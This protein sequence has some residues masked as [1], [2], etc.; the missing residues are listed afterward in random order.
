M[1][2]NFL[3]NGNPHTLYTRTHHI[4]NNMQPTSKQQ[5][6]LTIVK[7]SAGSGKTFA[8]A[9]T[10]INILIQNPYAYRNILAVTFTNKATEEMKMR[11]L[12]QLYGIAN[13]L[14][15]S[16]DYLKEIIAHTQLPPQV[17]RQRA[18][19][20]LQLL[21]HNYTYFRVETIDAFFQSV[22]RNLARELDLT[23]NLRVE[24][25]DKQVQ[26]KAVDQLINQL[27]P[28]NQLLTWI[29]Q[30]AKEKINDE[31][32]W[33]VI[34]TI[35]KFGYNIFKDAYKAYHD[36]LQKALQQKNFFTTY[37][38]LLYSIK[39]N[40]VSQWNKAAILFDETLQQYGATID[41]LANK[42]AGPAGYFLKLKKGIYDTNSLIKARV[43]NAM[44]KP[45]T[46]LTK[47]QQKDEH[48]MQLATQ[49]TLLLNKVEQQRKQLIKNYQTAN[50]ILKHLAEIRL[51]SSI[52]NKVR[53][54][55]NESGSFLLSDTQHL[56]NL[57]IEDSDSPFIFEKI[58]TQI[59]HVMIDEFQDT[60]TIQWKNFKILLNEAISHDEG[61]A[62][63]VG[64]VKQ[65]IYRWRSGDWRLLNNIEK[66]FQ[67]HQQQIHVKTLETNYRS[68]KNIVNFNNA[69]FTIAVQ[70][71]YYN[72]VNDNNTEAQQVQRAYADVIQN[73][74]QKK[75]NNGYVQLTLLPNDDNLP[76][77]MFDSMLNTIQLL[78][79]QG[80]KQSS[81]ALLIRTNSLIHTI[82]DKLMQAM[83]NIKLVSDEAFRLDSSNAVNI[84]IDALQTLMHPD[85]MI[86]KANLA[87]TYQQ[88]V[89]HRNLSDNQLLVKGI[90][91]D[92][93]LPTT[94]IQQ[95]DTLRTLPAIELVEQLFNIFQLQTL[96]EE[97]A[98]L[99]TFY[100]ILAQYLTDNLN[101][102]DSFIEQW[103]L[104]LHST[105]IQSDGIEGIRI[106]TIHKSKG[107]E[108]DHVIIPYCDWTLEPSDD[109]ILWCHT[110]I[111]PFAKLPIIPID[112]AKNKMQETYFEP[113]YNEEHLQNMVDN[114]NILY[115][116]FT[117][118]CKN[119]FVF[120]KRT[121]KS[122][123]IIR[124]KLI[125]DSILS[126]HQHLENSI[127]EG[128][129]NNVK[130][131]ISLTYGNLYIPEGKKKKLSNNVFLQPINTH[132]VQIQ[133]FDNNVEFMQ[134]NQSK[135]F[136]Q[137]DDN[138]P[139]NNDNQQN[140][141]Q[142]GNI[143]HQ[144]FSKIK[145][146][147]DINPVLK[148][149]ELNGVL[150]DEQI[151]QQKLQILLQSRL[152]Q[153]KVAEWFSN[154]WRVFNE[155]NIIQINPVD[156]K[157]TTYRPDRVMANNEQVIVVDFKFGK[158]KP[159]YH[160][161]IKRY[162][163]LLTNMGYHNV[164]GYLWF[165]YSNIIEEVI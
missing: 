4:Y 150:Y 157:L 82:A 132:T 125:E 96:K 101:A 53:E 159:Q 45:E 66:E 158:P 69:F 118:A 36:Q 107:L 33:N 1:V 18:S 21:L 163:N 148:Q 155:C 138:Q 115:V 110:D 74:P 57:L 137:Q 92:S 91:I 70:N 81:I 144:L 105:P 124:S 62:L 44:L 90:D 86:T 59:K 25:N 63:I 134:S 165:V 97:S 14:D 135:E 156:G 43:Q 160:D 34:N 65:S 120:A 51:L 40:A 130:D 26:E 52:E 22:L 139:T 68:E 131:T 16:N 8:L 122:R 143:L 87:K 55:N 56:L 149:L 146:I 64:D 11:I 116:A 109:V 140:Y 58:G 111:E 60:S 108:F 136:V 152:Q 102:I 75:G 98:Y 24:L 123:K 112:Y 121:D 17:I 19:K 27:Q 162:T 29:L 35:K 54:L 79:Q 161:Q 67:N 76:D 32:S 154:K 114:M 6:A 84:L 20:A 15:D 41:M 37:T 30:Y 38:Q 23:P 7:A 5:K 10:Y 42:T 89:L 141:I 88:T 128:D 78:L 153:P 145:T 49:L 72:L 83:P 2:S 3:E 80:A 61:S 99:C 9:T 95:Q 39:E 119:L 28:N 85:D 127:L 142:L 147:D 106:L 100:D 164:K 73:V 71:E 103:N 13:A 126:I 93:F 12:S 31:Q 104:N 46:W 151:T 117:R 50:L 48:L 133:S 129:L 77:N 94:F 47:E 113:H